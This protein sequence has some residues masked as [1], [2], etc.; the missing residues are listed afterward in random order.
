M[1]KSLYLIIFNVLL[2]L[3]ITSIS[4]Y[5]EAVIDITEMDIFELQE[6]IDNKFINY[7]TL[8]N[9]YLDRIEAYNSQYKAII[10]VN[11]NILEDA[12]KCDEEYSKNGRTTYL[13]C[14]PIIV[15]D[16]ID[17][18]GMPTTVGTKSLSD[19]YPKEDAQIIKNLKAKGALIIG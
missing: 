5:N 17:V 14:M 10:N 18:V 3:N 11:K 4:A 12:K 19:S 7:E 15:K 2:L 9:L 16:N 8:I 6:A 1:K 13:F